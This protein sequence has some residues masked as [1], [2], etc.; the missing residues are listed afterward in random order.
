MQASNVR[1]GMFIEYQN[2]LQEVI[3]FQHSTPG[4][5]RAFVQ[6]KLKNVLSGKIITTKFGA[7]DTVEDVHLDSKT[8]QYLYRD[9][10]G[11]HFMDM[12]DYHTFAFTPEAIGDDAFFLIENMELS[13]LFNHEHPVTLQL[14]R[15]IVLTVAE[16][17]PWVKGDSVSNN[18]KPVVLSTGLRIQVPLFIN[19]GEKVKVDTVERKYLSRA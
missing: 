6:L 16:A 14:P 19:Q 11:F 1:R 7:S 15:H 18:T 8:A 5:K 17:E 13:V 12:D 10:E 9:Q 4:N 2:N 3:D